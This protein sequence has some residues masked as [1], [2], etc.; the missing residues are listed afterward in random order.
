MPG[1]IFYEGKGAF[2]MNDRF[3]AVLLAGGDS[4]RMGGGRSKVLA[5]LGGQPALL[6]PLRVLCA[7]GHVKTL[8]LVCRE[9]EMDELAR[10]VREAGPLGG[11]TIRFAL[12]GR[13]RQD[14][15]WNG[16]QALGDECGYVLIHDGARPLVDPATVEAVCRDALEYGAATAAV[17]SK[18]TCKLAGPDGFVEG[19]PDRDRLWAVQTPQAFRR[20]LYLYGLE[21]ARAQGR[22]YT[23]DCQ[24]VEAAGGRVRLTKSGYHNFKLTTPEDLL[25]ARAMVGERSGAM[26]VGS[27]YDVHRLAEG[28]DLILG[29]VKIPYER[30]LLGHSDADVL[31]H[32]IADGLL[33]AAALGDIGQLFPDSDPRYAGADSLGLLST[34]CGLVRGQGYEIGNIDATLIAQKPKLAPHIP[35]MR[36]R[37]AAACGLEVGRVSVKATTEEGLGFTGRGEGIAAS[38]VCLLAEA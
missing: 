32:A 1:L 11:R 31:A 17:P 8:C 25:L 4:T 12:A 38:A 37:L 28:R 22:R 21:R 14:S 3:G 27:G 36:E 16:V 9:R 13:D 26:R 29:G 30:G 20:E 33:G 5:P 10:L 6:R 15:V 24:L 34:V 19:T 18:D 7:C 2:S 35:A 23:D